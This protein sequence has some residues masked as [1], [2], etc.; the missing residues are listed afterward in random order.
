MDKKESKRETDWF[1]VYVEKTGNGTSDPS[2]RKRNKKKRGGRGEA[3]G[4]VVGEG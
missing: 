2:M 4:V 1:K 3:E